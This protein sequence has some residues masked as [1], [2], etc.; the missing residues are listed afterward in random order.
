MEGKI[1]RIQEG[2]VITFNPKNKLVG[3]TKDSERIF[4]DGGDDKIIVTF[5]NNISDF[6]EFIEIIAETHG[7][8]VDWSSVKRGSD[9][10]ISF[11]VKG[12]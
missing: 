11:L 10:S 6:I 3:I 12:K 5:L 9:D 4:W 7:F 1:S 2:S 8:L